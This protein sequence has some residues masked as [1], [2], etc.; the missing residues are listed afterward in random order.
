MEGERKGEEGVEKGGWS[1]A[2]YKREGRKI[3]ESQEVRRGRREKERKRG[4]MM[5]EDNG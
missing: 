4:M 5:K 2:R 3:K 1:G